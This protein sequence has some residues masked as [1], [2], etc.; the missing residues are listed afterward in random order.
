MPASPSPDLAVVGAG[1][2]GLAVARG[3]TDAVGGTLHAEDTPGGGLTVEL[4]F[5]GT[6]L[7]EATNPVA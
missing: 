3:F 2:V 4:E 5:P 1:I 6:G 7:Y